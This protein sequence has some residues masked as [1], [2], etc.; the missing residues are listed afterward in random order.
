VPTLPAEVQAEF[1]VNAAE[2]SAMDDAAVRATRTA[3][4]ATGLA[5]DTGP[6]TTGLSG[7]SAE[8]LDALRS[9]VEAALDAGAASIEVTL[10]LRPEARTRDGAPGAS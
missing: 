2:S 7:T 1:T 4:V 6:T 10:Q 9:V 3:A 5:L 8:V